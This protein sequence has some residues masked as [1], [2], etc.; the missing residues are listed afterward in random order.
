MTDAS[1]AAAAP[2]R[3]DPAAIESRWQA[4][5]D[6]AGLFRAR[7]DD[8][9]KYYVLEMFPYPSG[10][11]HMGHVRNYTMGDVVARYK[12]ARGFSVLHPMGWDAFG[13]PAENAAAAS[14]G[15]PRDWTYRNIDT[16]R[17]QFRSLGLSFDWSREFATCDPEYYGQQQRL[18][19]DM[20]EAGLVYRRAATVNW[21][22][23]DQT[24]LANEQVIESV[25]C[26]QRDV[27][28]DQRAQLRGLARPGA[29]TAIDA[30][31]GPGLP[32]KAGSVRL[33]GDP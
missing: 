33:P 6:E 3:Y 5:W 28:C 32:R 23:V 9:P 14:G 30:A 26:E 2:A 21:D 20:L 16:M 8:R 15:H 18:F 31:I 19:L 1:P 13:L 7:R 25:V 10:N 4:A 24:V 12:G 29:T 17:E 11:L 27:A 22:P